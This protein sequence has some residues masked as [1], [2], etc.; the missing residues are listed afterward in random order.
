MSAQRTPKLS[1]VTRALQTAEKLHVDFTKID[2]TNLVVQE[3]LH[4]LFNLERRHKG[5]KN[6]ANLFK[7]NGF[8]TMGLGGLALLTNNGKKGIGAELGRSLGVVFL[9]T[10]VISY[11]ISIP[12]S[13]SAK[14]RV[15]ERDGFI[16][17]LYE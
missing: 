15:K 8:F 12:I 17:S 9:T 10:G 3:K 14:K 5:R 2:S 7:I 16:E 4:L 11:G 13:Y 1:K 6:S